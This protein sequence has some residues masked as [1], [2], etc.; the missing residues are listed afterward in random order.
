MHGSLKASGVFIACVMNKFCLWE[1]SSFFARG[2]FSEGLRRFHYDGID[3]RIA[4][5]TMHTWY[6]TPRQFMSRISRWF[7]IERVYGINIFSPSPNSRSFASNHPRLT[8]NLLAFDAH[9]R[10]I[11]PFNALGDH[12]V[13]EG[14]KRS[15]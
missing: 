8:R 11:F 1:M 15:T 14:R 12:F 3:A 13:I 4:G 6:Y 2:K 7:D 10:R 5:T 9:I